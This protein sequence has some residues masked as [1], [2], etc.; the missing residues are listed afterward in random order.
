ME[1]KCKNIMVKL[2]KKRTEFVDLK[3]KALQTNDKEEVIKCNKKIELI[4]EVLKDLRKSY[5]K[6][7][8]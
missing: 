3:W 8:D 2:M 6:I 7:N 5:M 1:D 4:D